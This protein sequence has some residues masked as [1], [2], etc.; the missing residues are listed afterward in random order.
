MRLAPPIVLGRQGVTHPEAP[1]PLLP[2]VASRE[3]R[4]RIARGENVADLVP[5]AVLSYALEQSLYSP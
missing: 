1:F 4:A 2:A 3:L 5:R